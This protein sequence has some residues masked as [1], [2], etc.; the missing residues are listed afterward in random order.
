MSFHS[1]TFVLGLTTSREGKVKSVLSC[2]CRVTGCQTVTF[3]TLNMNVH[4]L[5]IP[6]SS[7]RSVC[8]YSSIEEEAQEEEEEV[9]DSNEIVY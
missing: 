3:D 4:K 2:A 7:Q 9:S 5:L 8:V 1:L 6:Q